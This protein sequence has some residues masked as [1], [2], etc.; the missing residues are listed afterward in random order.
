[1][2]LPN[3]LWLPL[4]LIVSLL[5]CHQ[6]HGNLTAVKQEAMYI[7]GVWKAP[8]AKVAKQTVGSVSQTIAEAAQQNDPLAAVNPTTA[9]G[10]K[11]SQAAI[12]MPLPI[13]TISEPEALLPKAIEG[14]ERVGEP[15]TYQGRSLYRDRVVSPE[16]Y[17]NYGFR[18]QAEVEYRTPKFGST[19]L[20]LLEVFDM[21][22]PENAFGIYSFNNYPQAKFEWI[23]SKAIISGKYLRFWKGKYFIQIEG[24]EIATGIRD[25]MAALARATAKRIQD[26]PQKIPLLKLLPTLHV[27]GSEKLFTTNSAL[28]QLYKTLPQNI[29]QLM[30]RTIG[31][32]ARYRNSDSASLADTRI[33]F[34]LRFPTTKAAQSAHTQYR[35]A[36]ISEAV[37]FEMNAQDGIILIDEQ[38]F[39]KP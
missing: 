31:V 28:R 27:A 32:S 17:H 18:R 15:T 37:P 8:T 33:V 23:G 4:F 39:A 7:Y 19:P 21:G 12:D 6:E 38:Q 1:M 29:P 24:Y 30:E 26:T 5:S 3:T 10:Q 20:I 22:T 14:W 13:I 36:L 9:N 2:K 16:L 11:A 25:G 34:I 35:N